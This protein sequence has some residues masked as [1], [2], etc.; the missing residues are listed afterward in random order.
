MPTEFSYECRTTEETR[1]L[2]AAVAAIAAAGEVYALVGGLGAGKTEFVRGFVAELNA[3]AVV[4][5][6]TFSIVNTYSDGPY[7]I[8]HFDFY[9]LSDESEL[10]ELGFDDYTYGEGVCLIE[11]AD[12]FVDALPD[13]TKTIHFIE[14]REHGRLLKTDFEIRRGCVDRPGFA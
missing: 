7:P 12:M 14:K 11:W 6:P 4:R 10:Y 2:G 1:A 3:D 8:H 9:R 13:D 5:S